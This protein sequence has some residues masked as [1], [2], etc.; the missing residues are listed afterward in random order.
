[1]AAYTLGLVCAPAGPFR[2]DVLAED[3]ASVRRGDVLLRVEGNARAVLQGGADRPESGHPD[4]RGGHRHPGVGGRA[5]RDE[6]PG[7]GFAQ[8]GPGL[9]ML[10]KYAVRIGGGVNH[11][12][13]LADA[14]LIKDNHIWRPGEWCP[15]IGPSGPPFLRSASRWR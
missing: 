15:L 11:R 4:V 14:A 2:I 6:R 12:M 1:M 9:R 10:Q 13:S 7:P 8:D 5:G 3:G